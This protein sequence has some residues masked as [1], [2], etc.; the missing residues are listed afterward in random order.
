MWMDEPFGMFSV[1]DTL[2]PI[3]FFGVFAVVI[4]TFVVALVR[5]A[6]QWR[7]NNAAPVLTVEAEVV[8]KRLD[9]QTWRHAGDEHHMGH[10]SSRTYYYATFQVESGDRMEFQVPDTEYGLLVE[11]DRGKLTFQGTRYQGFRRQ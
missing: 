3:L 4:L 1:M 9:V 6:G 5:G 11:G 2:F 7:R 10:T 8:A